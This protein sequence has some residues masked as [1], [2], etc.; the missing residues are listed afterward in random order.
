MAVMVVGLVTAGRSEVAGREQGGE[1]RTASVRDVAANDTLNVRRAPDA[2]AAVV[3]RLPPDARDVR[4]TGR[5]RVAGKTTWWAV[6]SGGQVGWVNGR[7]LAIAPRAAG[8]PAPA[9]P[10]ADQ[11]ALDSPLVCYLRDPVWKLQIEEDGDA[12][13]TLMCHR[14]AGLRVAARRPVKGRPGTWSIEIRQP[15]GA[16][17]VTATVRRTGRCT[18]DLSARR[19]QYEISARLPHHTQAHGCCNPLS[20]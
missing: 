3:A 9:G 12:A 7:F 11:P 20:R 16:P 4:L 14:P 13:C 2:R 6:E 5:R 8:K 10:G 15:D 19:Y 1:P 18:E 17:F